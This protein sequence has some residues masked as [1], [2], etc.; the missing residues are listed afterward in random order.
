MYPG[1]FFILLKLSQRKYILVSCFVSRFNQCLMATYKYFNRD[2]SWLSFNHR[3]LL[4]AKDSSLPLFERIKFLAIYSNNLEEF[5]Q[6]RVSYYRQ[7]LKNAHLFPDK[8]DEVKPLKILHQINETVMQYQEEFHKIFDNEIVPELEKENI[9]LL[10]KNSKL[11]PE[12][13]NEIREIFT[14]DIL[15]TLQPVLLVKKRIRPFLKTGQVYIIAEMVVKDNTRQYKTEKQKRYGLIKLPT[16]HNITRFIELSES[17]GKYYIMFLEDVI[18]LHA[19]KLFT[20]Y[21]ITEWYTIKLTRDADYEYDDYEED[22]LIEAVSKL[23]SSRKLGKPNRFLYDKNMSNHIVKYMRETFKLNSDILVRG[24][25]YHN[26]RDFF[27]FPNPCSPD[28][29]YEKLP[30]LRIPDFDAESLIKNAINEKD[31]LISFPYQSYDYLLRFL[32]QAAEDDT[33]T[34]IKA[35]QYR[36]ADRSAVVNALMSAAENGKKVT[37]FVELKARFDEE[38]NLRYASEMT[39]AGITII[40]SIP[41]LKVHAKAAIIIRDQNRFQNAKNQ[42]YIGTGNFNE[43]TARLYCDHG[44]FTSDQR[45]ITD[46]EAMFTYLETQNEKIRFKHLLI[47]NFNLI[48]KFGRLIRQEIDNVKK[49]KKGYILLKM[50]GLQDPSMIEMLYRASEAGV[51][52]DLIVRGICALKTG[53]KFSKNIRVIRILDRFLE[54]ARVFVFH[55]DGKPKVFI[56]SADWMKRNLYRRV[57]CICP[58]YDEG[59]QQELI[60]ILKIQLADNVKACQ[61]GSKMENIRIRNNKPLV[62]S[63]LATYEYLKEKYPKEIIER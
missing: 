36:V 30:P 47:A 43:K 41:R 54:H 38:N 27:S 18:M 29:E 8:V 2:L 19:N 45:I 26:F 14:L 37:V 17:N 11:T 33:V 58:V 20:G 48:S 56:G 21:N 28:L 59:I 61:I 9:I 23:S 40:Y 6:V 46:L 3:V 63:Q 55:N 50:N 31:Y 10:N 42:A 25:T 57:E 15:S 13:Q 51:K 34:E 32:E 22:E 4:E 7:L 16:D 5:Y 53:K 24:G 39:K 35:T 49:G 1:I 60:D 12:Q 52:V 44:L 62:Q